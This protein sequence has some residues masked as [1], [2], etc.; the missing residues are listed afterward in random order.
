MD[1]KKLYHM[2]IDAAE[3]AIEAIEAGDPIKAK[4]L[5]I[6]AEQQAEEIYI[7][8]SLSEE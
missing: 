3:K 5:L 6:G 2:M 7:E 8:E 1:Y 4:A